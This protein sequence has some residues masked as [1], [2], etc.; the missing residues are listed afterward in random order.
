MLAGAETIKQPKR[1]QNLI[2]FAEMARISRQLVRLADDVDVP[3]AVID[4]QTP[5]RDQEKLKDFV[6]VQG[7]KSLMALLG[8]QGAPST[9]ADNATSGESETITAPAVETVNYELVTTQDALVIG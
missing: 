7:F 1:R 9:Q 5:V 8:A 2:E 4:I 6:T 3:V